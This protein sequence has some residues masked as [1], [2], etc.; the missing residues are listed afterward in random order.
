MLGRDGNTRDL[1]PGLQVYEVEDVNAPKSVELLRRLRP[2]LVF[3]NGVSILKRPVID[4]PRL[5]VINM[6]TGIVPDYRGPVPEFWVLHNGEPDK[7]GVTVHWLTEEVDAG[8]VILQEHVPVDT[9]DDEITLRCKNARIGARL[10]AEA[11]T[12]IAA[13]NLHA[14]PQ[15]HSQGKL[16]PMRTRRDDSVMRRRLRQWRREAKGLATDAT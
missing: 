12:R 4:I 11:V 5:G 3:C 10:V 8:D 2:I 13:G 14:V 7:N 1:L 6:H 9:A 16:Y 15:D